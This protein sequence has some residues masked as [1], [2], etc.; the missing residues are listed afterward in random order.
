MHADIAETSRE[1]Y[2]G[3]KTS[4]RVKAVQ[5]RILAFMRD[6]RLPVTRQAL[7]HYLG[8]PINVICGRVN[9]L[10]QDQKLEVASRTRV[11]HDGRPCKSREQL[12]LPTE[13]Y[14]LFGKSDKA[15][16]IEEARA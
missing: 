4:G 2:A 16:A 13:Q 8:E 7:A 3:A 14:P 15:K 5:E 12:R 6:W 10:I 9:E 1:A 11:D